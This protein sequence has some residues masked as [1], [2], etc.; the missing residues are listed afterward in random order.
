MTEPAKQELGEEEI[1]RQVILMGNTTNTDDLHILIFGY[2]TLTL[3]KRKD[4]KEDKQVTA[5]HRH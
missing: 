5:A 1:G 4:R 3:K 2:E